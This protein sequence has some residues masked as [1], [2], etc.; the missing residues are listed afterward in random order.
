MTAKVLLV[1]DEVDILAFSALAVEELGF[2]CLKCQD[3][4]K[5]LKM[6][7]EQSPVLIVTDLNMPE[8]SGI[9]LI[10]QIKQDHPQLPIV[11]ITGYPDMGKTAKESVNTVLVKPFEISELQDCIKQII[12]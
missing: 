10:E 12:N 7:D 8:L 11:V 6:I 5:V 2:E 3:P 9:E 1:D 4:R